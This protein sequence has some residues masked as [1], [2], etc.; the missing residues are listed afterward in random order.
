MNLKIGVIALT[1]VL[2]AS[3][4]S[5][6]TIIQPDPASDSDSS[7]AAAAEG[8]GSDHK[9]PTRCRSEAEANGTAVE[10]CESQLGCSSLSPPKTT[11]CTGQPS[12]WVCTCK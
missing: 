6:G 1:L 3:A 7:S 8:K 2:F 12:R 10:F 9:G 4:G 5:A 11:T